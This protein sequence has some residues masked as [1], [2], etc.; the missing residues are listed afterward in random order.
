MCAV[1]W[2]NCVC[3]HR[4]FDNVFIGGADVCVC[5]MVYIWV[6]CVWSSVVVQL[7]VAWFRDGSV[8]VQLWFTCMSE[9]GMVGSDMC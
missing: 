4:W 3:V 6:R 9:F 1:Q 7:S 5:G 2:F 8:L